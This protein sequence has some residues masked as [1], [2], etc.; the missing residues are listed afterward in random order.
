MTPPVLSRHALRSVVRA[1]W[2]APAL[3]GLDRRLREQI[4]LHVSS[5]N[6][7]AV[8]SA[9]HGVKAQRVGMTSGEISCA[10][11]NLDD[12]ERTRAT[13]RYAEL[14]TLDLERAHREDVAA[15]ERVLPERERAAVRTLVDFFTFANRFNNTWERLLPGARLRRRW[16]GIR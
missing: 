3:R 11:G 5:V 1:L 8:C 9:V 2:A 10:R 4:I 6:S 13:L 14:R 12:D 16:L 15:F 7:C